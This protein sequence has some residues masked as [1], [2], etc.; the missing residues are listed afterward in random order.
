M[1]CKQPAS[2][3][4]LTVGSILIS[5]SVLGE[6]GDAPNRYAS[7]RARKNYATTS[8]V[9]V[10]SGKLRLITARRGG[11]RHLGDVCRR[12]AFG[13]VQASPGARA[14]YDSLRGRQKTH[15]QALRAVANRLVGILHA[16]LTKRVVYD[17]A[18][19]RFRA[20]SVSKSGLS[21]ALTGSNFGSE[22]S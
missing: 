18:V 21:C 14:Y 19:A 17:E 5:L 2:S 22:S 15:G 11:N 16:C 13:A 9:T 8:P 1:R 3:S 6:F 20:L 12:W 10:A 4:N 7:A